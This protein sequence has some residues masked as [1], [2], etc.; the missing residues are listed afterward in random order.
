MS[1]Y[2]FN[3]LYIQRIAK[4]NIQRITKYIIQ[5]MAETAM[6]LINASCY[7]LAYSPSLASM[8]NAETIYAIMDITNVSLNQNTFQFI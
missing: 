7:G 1:P 2:F 6:L 5:T 3:P 8:Y 4:Y